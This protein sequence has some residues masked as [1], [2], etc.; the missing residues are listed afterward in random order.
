MI[1]E[2]VVSVATYITALTR[3]LARYKDAIQRG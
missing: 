2:Q 1:Y 3:L